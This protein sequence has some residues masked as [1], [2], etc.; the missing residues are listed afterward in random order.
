MGQGK[1]PIAKNNGKYSAV[2]IKFDNGVRL[3][4][5]MQKSGVITDMAG[6]KILNTNGL[7]IDDIVSRAI[8]QGAEVTTYNKKQLSDRDVAKKKDR[9]LTREFLNH[10]DVRARGKDYKAPKKFWKGH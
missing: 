1:S 8:S 2:E 9:E 3:S 4:Y 5:R 6:T 7:S 10:H